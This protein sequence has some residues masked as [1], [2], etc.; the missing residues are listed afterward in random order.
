MT[1]RGP[2]E[3]EEGWL[4]RPGGRLRPNKGAGKAAQR[5]GR[6]DGLGEGGGPEGGEGRA[7][8]PGRKLEPGQH[9]KKK[10]PF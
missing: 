4:A 6:G 10:N 1:R 2:R 9:K 5:E 8:R 7:G 3:G